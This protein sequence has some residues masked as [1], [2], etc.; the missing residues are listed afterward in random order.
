MSRLT[1]TQK[2]GLRPLP[3]KANDNFPE[4]KLSKAE[5]EISVLIEKGIASQ[6]DK[7]LCQY[8]LAVCNFR[9]AMAQNTKKSAGEFFREIERIGKRAIPLGFITEDLIA[10]NK[11]LLNK[12]TVELEAIMESLKKILK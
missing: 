5:K 9:M 2:K 11:T 12:K 1:R 6:K 4:R 3:L 7:F 10:L 8:L